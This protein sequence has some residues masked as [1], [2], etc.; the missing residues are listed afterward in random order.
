MLVCRKESE[1]KERLMHQLLH[2]ALMLRARA[3]VS[4]YR[5]GSRYEPCKVVLVGLHQRYAY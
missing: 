4:D 1:V 3:E 5:Y 2:P